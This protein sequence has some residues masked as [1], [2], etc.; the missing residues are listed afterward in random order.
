MT[1]GISGLIVLKVEI[2]ETQ[3]RLRLRTAVVEE[4]IDLLNRKVIVLTGSRSFVTETSSSDWDFFGSEKDLIPYFK[5][6]ESGGFKTVYNSGYDNDVSVK[7]VMRFLDK[8]GFQ[9]DIQIIKDEWIESK[10]N[11]QKFLLDVRAFFPGYETPFKSKS[12]M[13]KLWRRLLLSL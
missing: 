3:D 5:T 13:K 12:L 10:M 11:A 8:D 1:T 9:I 6:L 4:M 2:R 7:E